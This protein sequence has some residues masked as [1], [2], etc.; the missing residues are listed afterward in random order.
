MGISMELGQYTLAEYRSQH[1][2]GIIEIFD[3]KCSPRPSPT[4]D[5]LDLVDRFFSVLHS[6]LPEYD[7][8]TAPFFLCPLATPN[9]PDGDVTDLVVPALTLLSDRCQL[10]S[11]G[12]FGIPN[13]VVEIASYRLTPS[14]LH[15]KQLLYQ[16]ARIPEWWLIFPDSHKI[17][18]FSWC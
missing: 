8:R 15:Q 16:K 13:L 5:Q 14:T 17:Q 7:L 3:G 18:V 11:G 2:N 12:C 9:T 6:H 1:C 10:I 4:S